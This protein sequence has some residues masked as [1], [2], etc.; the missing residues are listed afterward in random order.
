MKPLAGY[1]RVSRR[2]ER[3][4]PSYISPSVQQDKIEGW[5]RLHDAELAEIV[6]EED[7]SGSRRVEERELGRLIEE[8]E[9][10]ELG[11][12]VVYRLDRFGRSAVE[13]LLAVARLREA[14]A[15]LVGVEDGVDSAKP[16][17]KLVIAVLA[18]LA[19]EQLDRICATWRESQERAIERGVHFASRTPFGY[20]RRRGA[21]LEADPEHALLVADAFEKKAAGASYSEVAAFLTEQTGVGPL[22]STQWT[23]GAVKRMLGNRVYLGRLPMRNTSRDAH[24]AVVDEA[25]WQA[26][27]NGATVSPLRTSGDG[28][29]LHGILRCAGCRHAMLRTA[30][31]E[32][33]TGGPYREYRCRREH[34]SGTC[35]ASGSIQTDVIE[36]Y[37][38]EQFFAA[39]E[40]EGI[41]A[42]RVADDSEIEN[43]RAEVELA[44]LELAAWVETFSVAELGRELF[45]E[46]LRARE[47]RLDEARAAYGALASSTATALSETRSLAAA[48]PTLP[49]VEQRRILAAGIGAIFLR[50]GG[51]SLPIEER[52]HICWRGEEPDDLPRRGIARSLEP[53]AWPGDINDERAALASRPP[54]VKR[55]TTPAGAPSSVV[56]PADD[57]RRRGYAQR[58]EK[59]T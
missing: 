37:V 36:S 42:A 54:E 10:G 12:V 49:L 57:V 3:S 39:L 13:T 28:A 24:E 45:L 33:K 16:G 9:R 21:P 22:T 25:I 41:L 53:F 26:A 31:R 19:E 20:V 29:L 18:A 52:V 2:G 35:P 58:E 1:V 55:R 32:R 47:T 4:G 50:R 27:Q 11:G 48:W 5:A 6:V 30:K 7:V 15:R 59:T 14:G 51:R 44:E 17:G 38:V 43:V 23:A 8:C 46:G 40:P 34:A 56:E